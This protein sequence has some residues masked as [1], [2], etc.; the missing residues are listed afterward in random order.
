MSRRSDFARLPATALL[1]ALALAFPVGCTT[2]AVDM[3]LAQR[4]ERHKAAFQ[5]NGETFPHHSGMMNE[6]WV[7]TGGP[8]KQSFS[9]KLRVT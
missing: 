4:L 7:V 3:L 6:K 2:E 9:S 8:R 5:P 1:L